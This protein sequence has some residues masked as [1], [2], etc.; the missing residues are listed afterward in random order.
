MG[1]FFSS[2]DGD[3]SLQQ[4]ANRLDVP[5]DEQRI[6][7][8]LDDLDESINTVVSAA[9]LDRRSFGSAP[10][11]DASPV[12]KASAL[13]QAIDDDVVSLASPDGEASGRSGRDEGVPSSIAGDIAQ[14]RAPSD[15][16]ARKLLDELA[17]PGGPEAIRDVL[18]DTIERLERYRS[19]EN[20]LTATDD[21]VQNPRN[22]QREVERI[23]DGPVPDVVVNLIETLTE[24][25]ERLDTVE[26][27]RDRLAEA[28]NA[29]AEQRD[30]EGEDV[31][32]CAETLQIRPRNSHRESAEEYG[33]APFGGAVAADLDPES[34]IADELV[35]NLSDP[36]AN[37]IPAVEE[38]VSA[39]DRSETLRSVVAE[40]DR[41]SVKELAEKVRNRAK[42]EN[43]PVA[44]AMATRASR[45]L[46]AIERASAANDAPVYA[47]EREL[48][49]YDETLLDSI[50]SGID[51]NN[52]PAEADA[53]EL[54]DHVEERTTRLKREYVDRLSDHNHSIPMHF[55]RLA[56]TLADEASEHREGGDPEVALGFLRAADA[57]LDGVEDLYE[58]NE[59]SMMLRRLRG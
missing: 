46:S 50:N 9:D 25:R 15:R 23:D 54:G 6:L 12:E 24:T 35:E 19:L 28:V 42:S 30:I 22:T 18:V 29:V 21:I 48:R 38:A 27:E 2:D 49:F 32:D 33:D 55:L 57:L 14:S 8:R 37:P 16:T 39:L 31:L 3:D 52:R 1:S 7:D 43:D 53:R 5:A 45:L 13:A 11:P 47:A 51:R 41:D 26:S 34:R 17:A 4:I 10:A 59:F 44:N 20:A 56:E 40:T 36:A 58:L